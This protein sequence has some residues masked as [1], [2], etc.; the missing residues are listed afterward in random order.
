MDCHA[1]FMFL[2][3]IGGRGIVREMANSCQGR[4]LSALLASAA[5]ALAPA[6]DQSD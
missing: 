4:G 2:A 6:P 1:F 5:A 3:R